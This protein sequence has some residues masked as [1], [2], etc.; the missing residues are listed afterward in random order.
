MNNNNNNVTLQ[1]LLEQTLT[2]FDGGWLVD[3]GTLLHPRD[4]II[5]GGPYGIRD[6]FPYKPSLAVRTVYDVWRTI[7][8]GR[9]VYETNA[10]AA[11]ILQGLAS[12]VIGGGLSVKVGAKRGKQLSQDVIAEIED[13]INTFRQRN[14]IPAWE[15]ECFI[16]GHRDG[17]A[18]LRLFPSDVTSAL[19]AIEPDQLRPP[20]NES[21]E[22]QWSF[23]I[24]TEVD[25]WATPIAYS[26]YYFQ[27]RHEIVP[28]DRIVH[29]KL[30]VDRQRKMGISSFWPV[31]NE[32]EGSARVRWA[33]REG[34][35]ARQ[36]IAYVRQHAAAEQG[37]IRAFQQ[38]QV[39]GNIEIP[40]ISG[41]RMNVDISQQQPGS[42]V[43]IPQSLE[44]QP[45]PELSGEGAAK[46]IQKSLE[47]VAA[48]FNV[49]YWLVSGIDASS[50]YASAVIVNGPFLRRVEIEQRIHADFWR[51]V[52]TK[53]LQIEVEKRNLQQGLLDDI[54][55]YISG[56]VPVIAERKESIEADMVLVKAGVMSKRTLAAKN[57]L[58]LDEELAEI[59]EESN[60]AAPAKEVEP[61]VNVVV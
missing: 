1:S 23:G 50:S 6:L 18:I 17:N 34:E 46:A 48:R 56:P 16:R 4:S 31:W 47:V 10:S 33:W 53:M 43:D 24:L 15:Y 37:V 25:D 28:V 38:S 41:G 51:E 29:L 12:Y 26:V 54:E 7:A 58:D 2:S 36:A 61:T 55:I 42:V 9:W 60:M 35:K 14:N 19:R 57:D 52:Y 3:F 44:F 59:A 39:T 11:G 13:I 22:G 45:P 40:Q 32:L 20:P 27:D 8:I 5:R 49:P 30:N 21:H